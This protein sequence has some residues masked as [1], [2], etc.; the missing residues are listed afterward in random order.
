MRRILIPNIGN[1]LPVLGSNG[2]ETGVVDWFNHPKKTF[3]LHGGGMVLTI[4][5]LVRKLEVSVEYDFNVSFNIEDRVYLGATLGV[6]D[7]NYD[8]YTSY[9]ENLNDDKGADNGGYTLDNY[10]RLEGTGMDLKLGVIV[11]PIESSPFRLG[12]AV[13]TPTWYDLRESY[14]ATLSSDILAYE[15]PYIQTLSDFLVTPEYDYLTY[16]YN[17][18]TPWKFNVSAGNNYFCGCGGSRCGI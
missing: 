7:V 17:L 2:G 5:S 16:D 3:M 1:Q 8:R 10:Y 6:Y 14:N 4:T 18:T 12:F 9:T 13:H 11:R 15:K